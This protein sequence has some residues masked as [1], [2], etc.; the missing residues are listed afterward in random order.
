MPASFIMAPN[1][2]SMGNTWEVLIIVP[3][4]EF[5]DDLV[6]VGFQVRSKHGIILRSKNLSRHANLI[7]LFLGEE[8]RVSG[9]DRINKRVICQVNYFLYVRD[10]EVGLLFF[11]SWKTAHP[12]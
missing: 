2:E 12:P 8:R 10:V 1:S 5:G 6:G 9:G 11:P 7:D 4:V 3:N